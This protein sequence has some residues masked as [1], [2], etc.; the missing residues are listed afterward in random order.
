[1]YLLD[2]SIDPTNYTNPIQNYFQ[3]VSN[4]MGNSETFVE[5]YMHFAPV[6]MR[7]KVGAIFSTYSDINS[8]FFDFNRKGTAESYNKFLLKN[9]YL[10]QNNINIYER[11][12]DGVLDI[13]SYIGGIAQLLF[14]IFFTFNYI[15][16]K[17]IIIMDT[18]HFFCKIERSSQAENNNSLKE[19]FNNLK[20]NLTQNDPKL[21]PNRKSIFNLNYNVKNQLDIKI[22]ENKSE[23]KEKEEQNISKLKNNQVKK[24]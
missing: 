9:Y 8:F 15:Y 19:I 18:N 14:N 11:R 4:G 22:S 16:N 10:M 13:L 7:T 12:Y 24:K 2:N 6:R 23:S 3:I 20:K 17:Y 5:N 21:I 1:M